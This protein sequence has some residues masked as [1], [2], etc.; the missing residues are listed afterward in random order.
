ME[1]EIIFIQERLI[2]LAI[3]YMEYM[4]DL[5]FINLQN[6]VYDAAH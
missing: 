5:M 2:A 3:E 6:D 4:Y 1:T